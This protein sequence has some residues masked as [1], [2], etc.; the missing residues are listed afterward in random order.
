M[1]NVGTKTMVRDS[2]SGRGDK[3]MMEPNKNYTNWFDKAILMA[4][5]TGLQ[6]KLFTRCQ[7]CGV[8]AEDNQGEWGLA[9]R[10]CKDEFTNA[11]RHAKDRIMARRYDYR[12]RK[13]IEGL[14]RHWH[15]YD[16][17]KISP[18]GKPSLDYDYV[19]LYNPVTKEESLRD[20]R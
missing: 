19:N 16:W 12:T 4:D 11:L 7:Y 17:D 2:Y 6:R 13:W 10:E 9:C 1:G 14:T 5:T 18:N 8:S 15:E 20:R 3:I